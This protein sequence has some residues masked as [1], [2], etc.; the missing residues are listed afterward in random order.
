MTEE[1]MRV[2]VLKT[3]LMMKA[4][5]GNRNPEPHRVQARWSKVSEPQVGCGGCVHTI[6]MMK[7]KKRRRANLTQNR[8]MGRPL[9]EHP[10]VD[11]L[12]TGPRSWVSLTVLRSSL[13]YNL[14]VT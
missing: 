13:T 3:C 6:L 8:F 7:T 1:G 4:L 10:D 11:L 2:R 9:D 12:E 14:F 5:M